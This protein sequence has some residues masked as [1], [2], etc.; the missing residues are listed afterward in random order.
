MENSTLQSQS[1]SLLSQINTLQNSNVTLEASK[2]KV[3]FKG[4]PKSLLGFL[5]RCFSPSFFQLEESSRQ[6]QS[7]RQELL[8][9]QNGLQKLHDNLQVEYEALKTEKDAQRE[10]EK[11][12]RG[13]LRKLQVY[14]PDLLFGLLE[15]ISGWLH[16]KTKGTL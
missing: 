11:K 16:Q 4:T 1:T 10:T 14:H 2:K 6:W 8:Q 12:L 9:D 3:Y 13:D 15:N 5:R 7:E